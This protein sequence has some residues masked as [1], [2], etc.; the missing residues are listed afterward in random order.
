MVYFC[1]NIESYFSI[2]FLKKLKKFRLLGDK[3]F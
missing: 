1:V 2:C 3:N